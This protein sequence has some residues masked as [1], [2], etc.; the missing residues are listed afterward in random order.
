MCKIIDINLLF[1]Y[2]VLWSLLS[3]PL[4][5]I[6][7]TFASVPWPLFLIPEGLFDITTAKVMEFFSQVCPDVDQVVLAE[8][9]LERWRPDHIE[10][11]VISRVVNEHDRDLIRQGAK[12]VHDAFVLLLKEAR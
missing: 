4:L 10:D 9:Q 7:V 11:R 1:G 2:D 12:R 5:Q 8:A 6:E 3:D